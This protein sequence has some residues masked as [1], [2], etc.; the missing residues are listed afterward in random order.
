MKSLLLFLLSVLPVVRSEPPGYRPTGTGLLYVRT[1]LNLEL[2]A[3]DLT[4]VVYPDLFCL[5]HFIS[6]M[7]DKMF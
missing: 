4:E 7:L 1:E 5:H 6:T 2:I 3:C